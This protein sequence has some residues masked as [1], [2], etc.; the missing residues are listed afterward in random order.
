MSQLVG[1]RSLSEL[2][3]I[4]NGPQSISWRQF[5]LGKR[6]SNCS[7]FWPYIVCVGLGAKLS[8]ALVGLWIR[9]EVLAIILAHFVV[10]FACRSRRIRWAIMLVLENNSSVD[11]D[12]LVGKCWVFVVL[13]FLWFECPKMDSI[14]N[15]ES[16]FSF[17]SNALVEIQGCELT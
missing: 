6:C 2:E 10:N 3:L 8:R 7:G 13:F 5:E 14:V 1:W 16:Y 11:S 4:L 17:V 15:W 9:E 12:A